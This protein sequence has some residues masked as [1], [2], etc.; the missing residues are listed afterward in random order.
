MNS[1]GYNL[2][3]DNSGCIPSFP[4]GLPNGNDDYV[5]TAALP[6]DPLLGD[7]T[8]SPG[9]YLLPI[10]SPA[11]DKIPD[12]DCTYL[13]SEANPLF[14]AGDPVST[15]QAGNPRDSLCD[16]GASEV[17]PVWIQVLSGGLDIPDETGVADFGSTP[18]GIPVTKTFTVRNIGKTEALT[19][20]NLTV[21]GGF[22][23]ASDFGVSTV[24][25][26]TQT[27]FTIQFDALEGMASS[28]QISFTNNVADQ[29][30]FNFML[31]GSVF[32]NNYVYLPVIL[33]NP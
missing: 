15:D 30:P 3:G 11:V 13:S 23:I 22:N 12:T 25:T 28:G 9:Y 19:L 18:E 21:P 2:I 24:L 7:L 14:T 16:I 5:G 6:L 4:G 29:S 20:A 32:T 26:N 17:P 10:D 33:T 1:F 8:G 27:S 31:M